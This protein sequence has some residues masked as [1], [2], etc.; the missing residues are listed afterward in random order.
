M[1]DLCC[2]WSHAYIMIQPACWIS[3][4]VTRGGSLDTCPSRFQRRLERFG[5]PSQKLDC[6]SPLYVYIV[7][8]NIK[9]NPSNCKKGWW[10]LC[11]CHST[12]LNNHLTTT[13]NWRIIVKVVVCVFI[14]MSASLRFITKTAVTKRKKFK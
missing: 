10:R 8:I 4:G 3:K 6:L 14:C 12:Q 9:C 13:K 2:V 7:Y 11:S 1:L 5:L